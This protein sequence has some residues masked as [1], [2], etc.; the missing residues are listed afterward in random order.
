M[1]SVTTVIAFLPCGH[2]ILITSLPLVVGILSC[3]E[4]LFYLLHI[5]ALY[6]VHAVSPP[7]FLYG[8]NVLSVQLRT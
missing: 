1:G 6:C 7:F 2:S 4:V 5:R 8:N 3:T